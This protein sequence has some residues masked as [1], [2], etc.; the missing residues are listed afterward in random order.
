M[1]A[2]IYLFEIKEYQEKNFIQTWKE[3]TNLIKEHAGGLG[4]VLHKKDNT[5]FIA[6]AQWPTKEIFE[7]AGEKLPKSVIDL[8][9]KMNE[10]II[11]MT[12]LEKF[13]VIENLLV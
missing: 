10:S 1:Y 8:R 11:K 12:V 5:N 6:Y 13:D 3:L 2:I 7:K 9:S 4:S